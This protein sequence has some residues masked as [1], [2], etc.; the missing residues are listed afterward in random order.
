MAEQGETTTGRE[1]QL[2]LD[3]FASLSREHA[4]NKECPDEHALC[5]ENLLGY[6]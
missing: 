4:V 5:M 3:K 6:D 2:F 1:E